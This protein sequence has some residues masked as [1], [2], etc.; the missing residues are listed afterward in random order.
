MYLSYLL[1]GECEMNKYEYIC[2][3]AAQFRKKFSNLYERK[4]KKPVFIDSS[5]LDNIE[6][7]PNT[8]KAELIGKSRIS[9]MNRE[10]FIINAEDE[11]GYKY[12]L[13]IDCSCYDF[14]KNDKLIYSVLHVDG[15]RWNVYK[16]NIYGYYDDNDLPVKSGELNWSRNLNFK[17]NR[18]DIIAYGL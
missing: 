13:D 5:L 17:L 15:A 7:I 9:R 11:N 8:I 4:E 6:D 10:D 14:Y 16:A 18:I 3:T 2:G 1:E 12:Y